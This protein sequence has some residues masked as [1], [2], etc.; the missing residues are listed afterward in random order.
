LLFSGGKVMAG[1]FEKPGYRNTEQALE[2]MREGIMRYGVKQVVIASTRGGTGLAAARLL[3]D[4]GVKLVVV[5]HNYGFKE[6]GTHEMT[7]ETRQEIETLGARVHTGTMPFR[8]IGTSI[9]EKM[10]YS[11]Q[12]LIANTLRIF[13]QGIKVCVEI[14]MMAADSGLI[15]HD[16]VLSVAGTAKGADT[17]ALISPQS[18]NS[19]FDLKVKDILVKP[20]SW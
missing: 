20:V 7:P 13:G 14:V 16:D 8:N 2:I 15:T 19:L 3:Q 9:R 18:S 1:T 4:T 17:V 6:P 11:Q 10:G 5:T 12:D